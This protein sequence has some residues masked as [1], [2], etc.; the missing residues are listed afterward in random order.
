MQIT[1]DLD[2][3]TGHRLHLFYKLV[4]LKKMVPGLKVTLFCIPAACTEPILQEVSQFDWV[5]LQQHGWS[6]GLYECKTLK[7]DDAVALLKRGQNKYYGKGFKAP[8]WLMSGEFFRAAQDLGYWLAIHPKQVKIAEEY[9]VKTYL[10]NSTILNP[11]N[12]PIIKATGHMEKC[13]CNDSIE[14]SWNNLLQIPKNAIFK[15][16]S[17]VV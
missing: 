17:E 9:N 4:K 16:V 6:H 14:D 5:E 13:V 3:F 12:A 1:I 8:N 2:D 15:F 10:F 7:Y 11:W